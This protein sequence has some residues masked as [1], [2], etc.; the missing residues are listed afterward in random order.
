MKNRILFSIFFML[1]SCQNK[2]ENTTTGNPLISIAATASGAAATAF[3]KPQNFLDL[4]FP[5]AIAYPPP[6]T[7][8]DAV[9]NTVVIQS[10]WINLGQIEF[11]YEESASGG[12]IDGAEVEFQGPYAID[13]LSD[14]PA[15]F[16]TGQISTSQMRRI[17][18]KLVRLELLPTGAPAGFISKSIYIQ[19]TVNGNSFS[20]STQDESVIE[21][22]GPQLVT[23]IQNKTLLLELHTANLIKKI[24]LTAISGTTNIDDSNRVASTNSCPTIHAGASDLFTCFLRGFETESNLGRDDDGDYKIDIEEE[25][26]K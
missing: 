13:L 24:D 18:V 23:A 26:V 15:T 17:K 20:Y 12:E 8:F 22:A 16:A 14:S 6:S 21:I 3:I 5:V 9:G 7:L 2:S 11:K 1:L 10:V 4:L 19:G 25:S